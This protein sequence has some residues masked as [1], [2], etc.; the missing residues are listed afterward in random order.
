MAGALAVL[1]GFLFA[2]YIITHDIRP[3]ASEPSQ[4]DLSDAVDVILMN[5]GLW[6]LHSDDLRRD[7]ELATDLD[8]EL[9]LFPKYQEWSE[10]ISDPRVKKIYQERLKHFKSCLDNTYDSSRMKQYRL[11]HSLPQPP[12]ND[13]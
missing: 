3:S 4:S 13:K 12:N 9:K 6:C 5:H 10:K 11:R 7:D 2:V 1:A 8:K